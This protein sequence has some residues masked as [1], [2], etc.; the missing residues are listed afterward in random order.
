M[1]ID[2]TKFYSHYLNDFHFVKAT[3]YNKMIDDLPRYEAEFFPEGLNEDGKR[4]FRRT[5]KTDLR[6]NYFHCIETFFELF[7]ALAP[8]GAP[9]FQDTNILFNLTNSRWNDNYKKISAI[10]DGS[11]R[12]DFLDN[13]VQG[14][15]GITVG[16]YLFYYG[17]FNFEKFNTDY[18]NRVHASVQAIK[19]GLK[20]L[21]F[22]FSNR[23]EYNSYKHG[24]RIIPTI[25]ELIFAR[26]DN[27]EIVL[28]FDLT[29]SLSYLIKQKNEDEIISKT[30]PMDSKRDFEMTRFCSNLIANITYLRKI[31]LEKDKPTGGEEGIPIPF[32][33]LEEIME[34]NK[35]SV[36]MTELTY[37]IKRVTE[38]TTND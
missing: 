7:F 19:H 37:S 13:E 34:C 35:R 18:K 29:D 23:D 5:L 32:F 21:A 26:V 38:S 28:K 25:S 6:Q 2:A 3:I 4:S 33:G 14:N 30:V 31:T 12:L 36:S 22:D 17:T 24:L 8:E 1:I 15:P 9:T 10:A 20:L 16:H 27:P 11:F